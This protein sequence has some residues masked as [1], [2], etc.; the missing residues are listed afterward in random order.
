MCGNVFCIIYV[1]IKKISSEDEIHRADMMTSLATSV[2]S[3]TSAVFGSLRE[4]GVPGV[5]F[6]ELSLVLFKV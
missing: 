6:H 4:S 2:L 5:P 1:K 3:I